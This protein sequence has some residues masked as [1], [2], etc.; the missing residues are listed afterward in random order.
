MKIAWIRISV[1]ITVLLEKSHNHLFLY[2]LWLFL[3]DSSRVV[4]PTE[5]PCS[6]SQMYPLS[7]DWQKSISPPAPNPYLLHFPFLWR[8]CNY[9]LSCDITSAKVGACSLLGNYCWHLERCLAHIRS[10]TNICPNSTFFKN[11]DFRGFT[12]SP[13]LLQE[14]EFHY[15]N[16]LSLFLSQK[17]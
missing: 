5:K 17:S 6:W 11:P 1:S 14:H 9:Y 2:C 13:T 10:S 15:C 7:V 12:G 16:W 3:S 8:M 4:I